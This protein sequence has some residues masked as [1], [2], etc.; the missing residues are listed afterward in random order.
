MAA[1]PTSRASYDGLQTPSV[2]PTKDAVAPTTSTWG[3]KLKNI[4]HGAT[5]I[6]IGAAIGIVIGYLLNRAD[7][8]AELVSWIGIPGNLFIRAIKCLV[9]PLVFSSLVVGM[10]DMLEAGKAGK[11]GWRTG[12][13]YVFT[14]LMGSIQGVIWVLI[15]RPLF[16][17][18]SKPVT[19]TVTEFALQCDKPG[20]FLS[21]V[22]DTITCAF[23]ESYNSTASFS[24]SSVFVVT[25]IN[26]SFATSAAEFLERTLSDA[27]QGQLYTMVPDNITAAFANSTLLSIIM[28]A[29][30]FGVAL[31]K[32]PKENANVSAFFREINLVFMNMIQ[33]VVLCTPIAIVSLLASSI[34]GQ[35]DLG[36]L[37]SDVGVYVLCVLLCV[38]GHMYIFYPI[39]IRIFVKTNPYSWLRKMLP[40]QIFAFG[41]ASSMASLPVVMRVVESTNVVTRNLSRFVLSL[42]ATIGMDGGAIMYP[43]AVVFMAESAGIGHIIGSVEYFLIIL[44]STIGAVGTGP[45]PASGI[46]MTMTTWSSVFPNVPLPS[47][48]AFIVACDWLLDRFFTAVNVTCDAVVCRIVAEQV[49]ET[50]E[51]EERSNLV[52]VTDALA[53]RRSEVKEALKEVEP[54]TEA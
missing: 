44:V 39:L 27:I 41:S 42:G 52:S 35:E 53:E 13:L 2:D 54:K 16:G 51:L 12:L 1:S 31:S 25:D 21:H 3:T 38:F 36:V 22:N 43:I 34:S 8:S 32:L 30:P 47:T 29:I 6:L 14:S 45:V 10:S 48:F 9:A 11:I 40:A 18:D 26:K 4:Y 46:V 17:N 24:S 15:F 19:E 5:G 37:V 7:P 28:F 50:V 49:G 20:Y 23:D 33:W